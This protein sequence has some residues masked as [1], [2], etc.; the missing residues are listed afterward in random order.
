MHAVSSV[1]SQML[2]QTLGACYMEG[3]RFSNLW[4]VPEESETS[5][6]S[7]CV[8]S[9]TQWKHASLTAFLCRKYGLF[10]VGSWAEKG[11]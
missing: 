6:L 4:L 5:K 9:D 8:K 1:I 3:N 2:L 7:G 10:D 11:K